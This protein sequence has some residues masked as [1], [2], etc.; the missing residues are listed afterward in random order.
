MDYV[1]PLKVLLI[2]VTPVVLML[3]SGLLLNGYLNWKLIEKG[4]VF[5]GYKYNDFEAYYAYQDG[6][7]ALLKEQ[8]L[9]IFLIFLGIGLLAV[10][11]IWI[12]Y[13]DNINLKRKKIYRI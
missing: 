5:T 3:L 7:G 9:I 4:I 6:L 13:K 11:I 2:V 1:K 10:L 12:R 8:G